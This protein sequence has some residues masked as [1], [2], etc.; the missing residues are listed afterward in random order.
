MPAFPGPAWE[1]NYRSAY[2]RCRAVHG[3]FR[4]R[5]HWLPTGDVPTP[6]MRDRPGQVPALR[7]APGRHP[8]RRKKSTACVRQQAVPA[9]PGRSLPMSAWRLTGLNEPPGA[10]RPWAPVGPS[11]PDVPPQMPGGAPRSPGHDRLATICRS[12]AQPL[13]RV[14]LRTAL[15][16]TR[17]GRSSITGKQYRRP[18]GRP[19]P[20]PP[21]RRRAASTPQLRQAAQ[22]CPEPKSIGRWTPRTLKRRPALAQRRVTQTR[23]ATTPQPQPSNTSIPAARMSENSATFD[24]SH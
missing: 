8:I 11:R 13:L 5:S 18:A 3:R 12:L 20:H 24:V 14:H 2:G 6:I 23:R 15:R 4:P 19:C 21:N 16:P 10:K 1:S 17:H 22:P 9:Q 7:P